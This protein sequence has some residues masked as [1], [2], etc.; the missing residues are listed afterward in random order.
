VFKL[1]PEPRYGITTALE[2]PELIPPPT[3]S[4]G[5]RIWDAKHYKAALRLIAANP[6]HAVRQK[7]AEAALKKVGIDKNPT[8]AEVVQSMVE[9]N[10]LSLR[11]YSNMAQD[12]P[13]EA[14]FKEEW[15]VEKRDSVVTMPS[16]AHLAAVLELEEK[17]QKQDVEER[18][19]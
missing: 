10:V 17:F 2:R 19:W 4:T 8:A 16:P 7:D 15:G 3:E 13:K 12:I 18:I 5:P 9:Y 1:L 6:Y 14:F 11:P